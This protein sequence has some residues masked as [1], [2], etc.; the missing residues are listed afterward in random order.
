MSNIDKKFRLVLI[1]FTLGTNFIEFGK[2]TQN[3]ILDQT[4][5]LKLRITLS[6]PQKT[7]TGEW[8]NNCCTI[9][10]YTCYRIR[11]LAK[12]PCSSHHTGSC[13]RQQRKGGQ[14]GHDS[15][16]YVL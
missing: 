2:Q 6:D 16:T 3:I 8:P 7:V 15:F 14:I 11:R 1:L 12:G 13:T 4:S 10:D 9:K 5:V